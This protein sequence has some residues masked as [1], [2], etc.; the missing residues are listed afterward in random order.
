MASAEDLLREEQRTLA[1]A[2]AVEKLPTTLASVFH[3][4][5]SGL[6]YE[7]I[8]AALKIPIGTVKSRMHA[9]V[10]HLRG[11]LDHDL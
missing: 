11:E 1:V 8:A 6:S 2:S 5:T 7:D 10:Q 3:L 4:R 9:L